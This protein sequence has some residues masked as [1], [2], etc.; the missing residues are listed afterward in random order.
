MDFT[1]TLDKHAPRTI[2]CSFIVFTACKVVLVPGYRSTDFLVHRHWK[3]LTREFHVTEWYHD[4]VETVHTLDYP[5]GFA[6]FEYF[7][8]NNPVT[9]FFLSREYID[10]RCLRCWSD[11]DIQQAPEIV[12]ASCVIFMR[13]SVVVSDILLWLGA[14]SAA[15]S[16]DNVKR[17]LVVFFALVL[18]P[19][20]LW[21]DHVHFQY[22]GFLLGLLM[23][24]ISGL[25]KGNRVKDGS[26]EFH[27]LH[28]SAAACFSLLL[29][30]KHLYLTLSPWYFVYLLRRY[31]CVNGK[32]NFNRFLSLGGSTIAV[33]LLP[34]CPWLLTSSPGIELR[35]IT[36]RLFPFDR[37]LVHD[38]WAGNVWA[39]WAAMQKIVG[40]VSSHRITEPTPGCVSLCLL[41]SLMPGAYRAHIAAMKQ[42]NQEILI[43]LAYCALASFMFAYHVHEKAIATALVP[44]T[45]LYL[46]YE[47]A[48][49][50]LIWVINA[51][52]LLGLFP[53][54]FKST[55]L[56][57][58]LSTFT[59]Y[60]AF[61]ASSTSR[62]AS[63]AVTV[64][65][66]IMVSIGILVFEVVPPSM[67]GKYE[68][69]P[70]AVVSLLTAAGLCRCFATMLFMPYS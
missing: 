14:W 26:K 54:F 10:A 9:S 28:L 64:P 37:G 47:I 5:P 33:L 51:F 16:C 55:E 12:G 35:Q 67:F 57:L 15:N 66:M 32:L 49:P 22:N 20:L 38:Y 42:S 31:C 24:S 17:R 21:L 36:L 70:L 8:A 27:F 62:Q 53:L 46:G 25:L 19:A 23:L 30:M 6:F 11:N 56:F 48:D 59:G 29:T 60:L 63:K 69:I 61:L 41:A 43:S 4:R 50:S 3:S 13:A 52:A 44:L 65:T 1:A 39:F 18:H 45:I 7:L 68:F 34:F 40:L 2:L 58:K